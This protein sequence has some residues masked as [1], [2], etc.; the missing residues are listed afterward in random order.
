MVKRD[1]LANKSIPLIDKGN[2]CRYFSTMIRSGT[3][4]LQAVDIL[5]TET[6]N[7]VLGAMLLEVK[8]D[9][10]KGKTLG[11]A[12]GRFPRAFDNTFLTVIK[13][14]EES[15]TLDKSLDYMGKQIIADYYLIQKVKGAL[16]YPMVIVFAMVIIGFVLMGGVLPKI[17]KVFLESGLPLPAMTKIIFGAS[18]FIQKFLPFFVGGFILSIIGIVIYI[19]GPGQA[20]SKKLLPHVPVVK[21]IFANLD[22]ARFTRVLGTL[23]QSGVP[24]VGALKIATESLT[25]AKYSKVGSNLEMEISKGT[26]IK[27]VLHRKGTQFP[28]MVIGM[29]AIGE[30]TG[31]LEKILF[32]I[33]EFYDQE[34][35]NS[36]K[37]FVT[38]L[39]P[40]LMVGV[41]IVVAIMV[42][43]IITPV[44]SLIGSIN[45]K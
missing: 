34:V 14:G 17:A 22:I 6:Q 45:V 18:L 19:K 21:K 20:V 29:I 36:L 37:N 44:Y 5:T 38:V 1:A 30:E 13:A 35:D 7:K 4:I 43:S 8:E 16:M 3:P 28:K 24:I 10:Q 9:L 42:F 40:V 27:D 33:A 2:L 23:L 32:D 11:D 39:E 25:L 12:L 41:G 31:T 26:S 15:G